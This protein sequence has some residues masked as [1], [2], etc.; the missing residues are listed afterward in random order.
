MALDDGGPLHV[1]VVDDDG[2]QVE[3]MGQRVGQVEAVP[4]VRQVRVG[5]SAVLP[6]REGGDLKDDA[7]PHQ[8]GEAHRHAVI[9]REW[10]GQ[11][12]QGVDEQ[13]RGA[14]VGSRH[15]DAIAHHD[16]L[17]IHHCGLESGPTDVDAEGEYIVWPG[18]GQGGHL[19]SFRG[20]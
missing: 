8:A 5:G 2:G 18:R 12:G 20:G 13:R 14:R 15:L 3:G 9:A 1:G 17:G 6:S 10:R 4:L 19:T 16:A 11:M 7:V